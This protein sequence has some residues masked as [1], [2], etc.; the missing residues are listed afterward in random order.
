MLEE[1]DREREGPG[2]PQRDR[3]RERGHN[4][5]PSQNLEDSVGAAAGLLGDRWTF[6]I[7][8]EAFFGARRFN[9]FA[10]NLGLSRNILSDRLKML[11]AQ[12]IFEQ[13]PYGPSGTRR[14]YRLA[15]AGRDIFPI[16]VAL[17]QWGDRHLSGSAGP[18]I[19]LKH[20]RCG[21]DADP[22]LICRSCREP[23]AL[24]EILPTAGPGAS[25]WVRGRLPGPDAG[26][27]AETARASKPAKPRQKAPAA[28]RARL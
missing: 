17:L 12:G 13:R 15:A 5:D 28:P 20:T 23:L 1:R 16:V 11:V 21:G 19:V 14:E 4:R 18:S 27:A 8:R 9:E 7:L 10:H 3:E 25:E 2:G 22:L 6:L 26:A 24:E